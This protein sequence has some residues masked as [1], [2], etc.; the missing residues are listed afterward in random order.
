M[1]KG[2]ENKKRREEEIP[3]EEMRSMRNHLHFWN[4]NSIFQKEYLKDLSEVTIGKGM[5]AD[6]QNIVKAITTSLLSQFEVKLSQLAMDV[7]PSMMKVKVEVKIYFQ[8]T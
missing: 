7:W 3:I 6:S 4:S 2:L 5:S 8:S 1:C